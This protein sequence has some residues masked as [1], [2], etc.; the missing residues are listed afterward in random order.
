M[1]RLASATVACASDCGHKIFSRV[2]TLIAIIGTLIAIIGTDY[3]NKG[4]DNGNKGTDN[5]NK[6]YLLKC[7]LGA[8]A[9]TV[10]KA[11]QLEDGRARLPL[12]RLLAIGPKPLKRTAAWA[13]DVLR[14][15]LIPSVAVLHLERDLSLASGSLALAQA[16]AAGSVG[17]G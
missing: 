2:S 8:R 13:E 3:G 6:G 9:F 7:G 14:L 12:G 10:A 1:A 11:G 4:T 5:G 17:W 16:A 15:G